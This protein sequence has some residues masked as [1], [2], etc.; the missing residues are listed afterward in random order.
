MC[1]AKCTQGR[2]FMSDAQASRLQLYYIQ[3]FSIQF[4][5]RHRQ[6]SES[7]FLG[8]PFEVTIDLEIRYKSLLA[9]LNHRF[10]CCC[11]G[12]VFKNIETY[13]II[14]L[15]IS[16]LSALPIHSTLL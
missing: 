16:S 3:L 2:V 7:L 15:F 13:S 8:N 1:L 4:S 11:M 5:L 10:F 12:K 6:F 14:K 9:F